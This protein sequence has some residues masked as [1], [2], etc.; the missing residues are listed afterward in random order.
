MILRCS[1]QLRLAPHAGIVI[2]IGIDLAAA[3][4]IGAALGHDVYA[5]AELLP[6]AEAGLVA[7]LNTRL[8]EER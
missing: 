2:V 3:L 4:A 5:L 8:S 7:A 6:A 1:G